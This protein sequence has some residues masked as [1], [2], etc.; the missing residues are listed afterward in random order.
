MN[1]IIVQSTAGVTLAGGGGFSLKLLETARKWAPRVVAADGGADRLLRLGVEPEAVIGDFDSI[2]A[3]ARTRLAG[4]LF[5][6][7]EQATTD[8]DKALRSIRAPFV[9]G[10]GFAGA[11]LDHGLAVLNGLVSHPDRICLILGAR[12]VVFLAPLQMRLDLKV[13][14]RLSLFPMGAVEGDSEGLRWPLQGLQFAPDGVIGTSNEVTG[15]VRLQFSARRMLVILPR[16]AMA[17]A[18][19]GFELSDVH[20][21]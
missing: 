7:P 10:V 9:I 1:G 13:G 21:R 2:T 19:D 5:P 8:F 16:S 14:S 17:A 3:E 6:I 18:L 20:G 12:D 15:P 11:R 4:R